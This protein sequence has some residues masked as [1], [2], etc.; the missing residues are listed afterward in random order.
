MFS[1]NAEGLANLVF[2]FIS[3]EFLTPLSWPNFNRIGLKQVVDNWITSG[4]VESREGM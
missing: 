2:S 4:H 3:F 1:S